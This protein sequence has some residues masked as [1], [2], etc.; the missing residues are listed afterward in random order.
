MSVDYDYVM[1]NKHDYLLPVAAQIMLRK[2][3]HETI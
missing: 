2:G 3:R 1:I